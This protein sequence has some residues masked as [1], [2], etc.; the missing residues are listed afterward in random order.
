LTGLAYFAFLLLPGGATAAAGDL[1]P[2]FG[3]NGRVTKGPGAAHSPAAALGGVVRQSDGKLVAAGYSGRDFAVARYKIDGSLDASFSHD[4]LKTTDFGGQDFG[5][6]LA[7]QP[8]GRILVAGR[9]DESG[10]N[11][12]GMARYHADGSLDATFSHDGMKTTDFGGADS[13]YRVAIQAD[14]KIVVVGVAHGGDFGVARYNADGTL[15]TTF[16][17]NGL[18]T[19]NFGGFDYADGVAIQADEKIVVGGS[20]AL[21]FAVARYNAHGTLDPSFSGDGKQTTDLGGYDDGG[22]LAIQ[23]DGG[24]VLVGEGTVDG[25]PDFGLARYDATDGGLDPSF[26]HDGL[27]TTDFGPSDAAL[28]V[29][30]QPDGRIVAVGDSHADLGGDFALARYNANGTLDTGFSGDG[31]L[32]TAFGDHPA[33]AA[34]AVAI[35]PNG[36]IVAAGVAGDNFALARYLGS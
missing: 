10:A 4:G 29:A 11:D 7:L 20:A 6:A 27:K 24:I 36:K 5:H 34:G 15:D 26:S 8:D 16:S 3:E 23:P 2:S 17:G 31:R 33:F 30:V 14:G 25:N 12:W 13:A 18:K 22:S 1:D 32:F 35:Q 19:T 21:D 9:V 28:G